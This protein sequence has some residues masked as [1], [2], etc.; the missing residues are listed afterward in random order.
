MSWRF[1]NLQLYGHCFAVRGQAT[2]TFKGNIMCLL[3]HIQTIG[4]QVDTT[5]FAHTNQKKHNISLENVGRGTSS[6]YHGSYF[7]AG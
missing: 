7:V 3:I 6:S 5:I 1:T 2:H 4:K